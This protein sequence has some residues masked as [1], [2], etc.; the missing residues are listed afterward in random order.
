MRTEATLTTALAAGL[1]VSLAVAVAPAQSAIPAADQQ[2]RGCALLGAA[3]ASKILG[4]PAHEI[5]ET[6]QKGPAPLKFNRGCI[7]A[8]G[9][10]NFGY[11][12]N[13]FKGVGPAKAVFNEMKTASLESTPTEI[14]QGSDNVKV[15]GY[16][17]FA[18][19][20]QLLPGEDEAPIVKDCIYNVV[21]RKGA[22]LFVTS[23]AADNLESTQML[24]AAAKVIVPR[25]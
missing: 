5:H 25:M 9:D 15:K 4:S 16:P 19:V 13:T 20:H 17:G 24:L 14:L 12:V 3:K 18:R 11:N 7:F 1:T 6:N 10:G 21:V 22:T 8:F 23:Y 2:I